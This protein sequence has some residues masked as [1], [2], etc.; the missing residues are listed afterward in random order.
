MKY[1][2]TNTDIA[3]SSADASANVDIVDVIGN[4]SD[5]SAGTSLV[6]ITK[7][8]SGSLASKA[9]TMNASNT[10]AN[11]NC[12]Q[13]TG[14]VNILKIYGILTAK[15]TLTNCTATYFDLYDSTAAVEITKSDGVLSGLAV[16]TTMIKTAVN[17]TTA[18]IIDNVAGAVSDTTF[19]PFFVEQKTGANTYIRFNYTTTDAPA[20]AVMTVYVEY[21]LLG[22]ATLTAV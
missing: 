12:F 9:V 3:V 4:K 7:R 2:I 22:G 13:I 11:V 19:L 14:T 8:T 21:R 20:N 17:T 1:S 10:T 5:T 16:G 6:S 18:T 15:T